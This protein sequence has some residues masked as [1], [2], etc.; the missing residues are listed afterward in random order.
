MS[1]E[2][3]ISLKEESRFEH[4]GVTIELIGKIISISYYLNNLYNKKKHI[5]NFK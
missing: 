2:V 4:V 3:A 1:G 5:L